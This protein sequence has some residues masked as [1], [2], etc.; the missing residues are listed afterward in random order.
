MQGDIIEY[1]GIISSGFFSTEDLTIG[2]KYVVIETLHYGYKIIDD[3]G[4]IWAY[5]KDLFINVSEDRR[6]KLG[7]ILNV[8]ES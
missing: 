6:N 8:V 7:R 3:A 2:Q 4:E 5:R 1:I